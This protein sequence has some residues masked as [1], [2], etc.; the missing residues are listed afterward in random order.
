MEGNKLSKQ[1][2]GSWSIYNDRLTRLY[3]RKSI[4]LKGNVREIKVLS[5][6]AAE[7]GTDGMTRG[8]AGAVLG[9]LVAGPVGTLL[10]A[11]AGASSAKRGKE[12][13]YSAI[14]TFKTFET[15][16]GDWTPFE[17]EQMRGY[18]PAEVPYPDSLPNTAVPQSTPAPAPAQRPGALPPPIKGRKTK[19]MPFT[20]HRLLT[21]L[22]ATGDDRLLHA[23]VDHL[24]TALDT[25]NTLK[26]RHYGEEIVSRA[27]VAGCL[28]LAVSVTAGLNVGSE[29]THL[30]DAPTAIAVLK[31]HVSPLLSPKRFDDAW[32][33]PL[34]SAVMSPA[35]VARLVEHGREEI[36]GSK[37]AAEAK[38]TPLPD[39]DVLEAKLLS[40]QKLL[41]KELISRDE[42]QAARAKALGL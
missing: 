36:G 26:W 4:A 8:A 5:H 39:E 12:E 7:A 30:A 14:V 6:Q 24:T 9:F 19:R 33:A 22:P 34:V 32:Q 23:F 41:D 31:P 28:A 27:E 15:L 40:L 20:D 21:E 2:A 16:V 25:Y 3:P 37:F 1:S 35:R 29:P 38:S 11:G 10:G 42:W 18:L 13:S 17:L